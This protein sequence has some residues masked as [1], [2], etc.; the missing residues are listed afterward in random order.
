[1]DVAS[2]NEHLR[3]QIEGL[4]TALRAAVESSSGNTGQ[5]ASEEL[6]KVRAQLEKERSEWN[7]EREQFELAAELFAKQSFSSF[8][9]VALQFVE[10]D[11]EDALKTYLLEKIENIAPRDK[12]QR[13]MIC[14]W[15]TEIF[16]HKLIYVVRAR[17]SRTARA[18]GKLFLA[19]PRRRTRAMTRSPRCSPNSETS[20]PIIRQASRACRHSDA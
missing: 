7:E 8:E 19:R 4:K 10:L 12:T 20:S 17:A 15:L 9:E 5:D 14:T 3:A 6:E 1:M 11:Q 18:L 16:L 13:T 2:E